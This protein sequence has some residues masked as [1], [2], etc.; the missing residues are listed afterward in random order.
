MFELVGDP[1][2]RAPDPAQRVQL[3]PRVHVH[4]VEVHRG[5]QRHLVAGQPFGVVDAPEACVLH[6]HVHRGL[7]RAER[8][9]LLVHPGEHGLAGEQHR[10]PV[11][12]EFGMPV[13][14]ALR[15]PADR[16]VQ[17]AVGVDELLQRPVQRSR[18]GSG[19]HLVQE[20]VAQLRFGG[21]G[22]VGVQ[23][24]IIHDPMHPLETRL[25]AEIG[26]QRLEAFHGEPVA[27]GQPH[28][29][30]G[31]PV[32]HGGHA[33][34]I[35]RVTLVI[36]P[37]LHRHARER[38]F[39]DLGGVGRHVRDAAGGEAGGHPLREQR[40]VGQ[41]QEPAVALSERDPA[42]AAELGAAQ[43]FE[44]TDDGVGEET[45]EIRGLRFGAAGG[46]PRHRMRVDAVRPSGAALVGQ[47]DAEVLDRLLDPPIAGRIQQPRPR[48]SRPSL[49]EHQQRQIVMHVLGGGDHAVEQADRFAVESFARRVAGP[50]ERHADRPVLDMQS[51]H[52][53]LRQ[54]R[55]RFRFSLSSRFGRFLGRFHDIRDARA[56]RSP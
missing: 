54:Q 4:V 35:L 30:A 29:L 46:Q 55:H 2:V 1:V 45:F 56:A 51:G 21:H 22:P 28:I 10:P 12:R 43:M 50:V 20:F 8:G 40:Q 47:Y 14:H 49:Q 18:T 26:A 6:Q 5:L 38:V 48:A 16:L 53:V 3:H 9:L 44:V 39:V 27:V 33:L 52:V 13:A 36:L 15:G 34:H 42:R 37:G 11:P 19:H 25:H 31:Q 41:G 24:R 17:L 32:G 7:E 23:E